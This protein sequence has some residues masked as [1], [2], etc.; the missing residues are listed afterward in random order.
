MLLL[1]SLGLFLFFIFLPV[2]GFFPVCF[3]FFFLWTVLSE[4][5]MYNYYYYY[6]YYFNIHCPRLL[7]YRTLTTVRHSAWREETTSLS[8]S[9]K[10]CSELSHWSILPAQF[11]NLGQGSAN[12]L[13]RGS[14]NE[15]I[16][17]GG[18][19]LLSEE[20]HSAYLNIVLF[21]LN[22]TICQ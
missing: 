9:Y 12:L 13:S 4:I 21:Y 7:G 8:V 20:K 19:R 22:K 17:L 18:P 10:S 15:M 1:N 11:R 6:Y 16:S 5:N 2:L 14:I 3:F